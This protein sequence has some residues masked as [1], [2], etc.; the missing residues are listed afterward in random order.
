MAVVFVGL[1]GGVDSAVSAALLKEQGYEVVGCFIKI[2]QPEFIECSWREDRLDAM[3]V[4]ASLGI[5]FREIDLSNEYKKEVVDGMVADYA[6]GV[7]PNPD[8]LCNTSIK[9]GHFMKWALAEGA[10]YIATGHYARILSGDRNSRHL[11]R[12]VDRNKDQS[13]FLWQLG[14]E[15]LSRTIFPIGELT[16]HEVRALARRFGLP[17][18]DKPDSQGLCFVGDV[19]M[20]EFLARFIPLKPGPVEGV[21]G[22][23]IGEHQGAALY[24]IGQRHGFSV[25]GSSSTHSHYVVSADTKDNTVVVSEDRADCERKEASLA[26]I[27]WIGDVPK[28]PFACAIQARYRE[29]PVVARVQKENG[30]IVVRTAE[31]HIFSPGQSLVLFQGDTCFGGGIIA[32]ANMR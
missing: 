14:Q 2:W 3:R 12:G 31:P 30:G 17:N 32:G 20:E 1:S 19:S 4:A 7:T 9:F 10:D 5:S 28:L 13:Y 25:S 11:L 21:S 8:V 23:K 15:E 16:K 22:K 27:H 29:T 24:T 18:S 6:R 26:N